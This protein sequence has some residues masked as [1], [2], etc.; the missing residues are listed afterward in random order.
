MREVV[1][2]PLAE[3]DL[4]GIWHYSYEQWGETQATR[5]LEQLEQDMKRLVDNPEIGCSREKMRPGY[6][7]LQIAR[8]V[9]FM[10]WRLTGSA[11][12]GY[13]MPRWTRIAIYRISATKKGCRGFN[14]VFKN[15]KDTSFFTKDLIRK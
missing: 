5:Y 6:G 3:Q 11:S 14:Q 15:H 1:K 2:R 8:H 4:K 7:S 9:I 12:G 10:P 13:C